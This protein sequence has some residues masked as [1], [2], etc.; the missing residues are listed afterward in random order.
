[1]ADFAT[2]SKSAHSYTCNPCEYE[3]R[4]KRDLAAHKQSHIN[5]ATKCNLCDFIGKS[6][7]ELKEHVVNKH[8]KQG[9]QKKCKDY[10][11]LQA[12]H[13]LLKENYERLIA[14]NKKLQAQSKDKEYALDVQVEELRG[15][16][17]K[18]K[19]ENI[20]LKDTIETQNKLW[21]IWLQKFEDKVEEPKQSN[22]IPNDVPV[23]SND[24]EK[25]ARRSSEE[26]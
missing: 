20:K 1:M 25:D 14:I 19:S 4:N 15:G 18:A 22:N 10:E 2:H 9:C 8:G 6:Y 5:S 24:K 17:E 23:D 11:N 3:V 13:N 7:E 26:D 12:N 21:K 16:Y